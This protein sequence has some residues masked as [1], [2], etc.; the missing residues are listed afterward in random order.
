MYRPNKAI[1]RVLKSAVARNARHGYA[2]IGR[3]ERREMRVSGGQWKEWYAISSMPLS[4]FSTHG[5]SL[6]LAETIDLLKFEMAK[7][8]Q[9][10]E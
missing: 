3:L 10:S 5:L 4:L 7:S 6:N 8:A 9:S 1:V 2:Q